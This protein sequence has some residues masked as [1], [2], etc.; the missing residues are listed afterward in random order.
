MNLLL[1]TYNGILRSHKESEIMPGGSNKDESRDYQV[2]SERDKYHVISLTCGIQNR[3]QMNSSTK[4]R[5]SDIEADWWLPR[6]RGLRAGW[7]GG[8]GPAGKTIPRRPDAQGPAAEHRELAA[9]P[10]GNRDR[11]EC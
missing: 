4:Q 9:A 8:W 3:T 2:K 7:S 5:Q 6:E 11:R 10:C 1:H